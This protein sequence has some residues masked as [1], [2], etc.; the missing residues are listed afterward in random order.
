LRTVFLYVVVC[1]VAFCFDLLCLLINNHKLQQMDIRDR[2]VWVVDLC[3]YALGEGEP[4]FA[5]ES[6]GGA[7]GLFG[8]GGPLGV[9]AGSPGGGCLSLGDLEK[10]NRGDAKTQ[11]GVEEFHISI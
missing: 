1:I 10:Q 2:D 9:F 7:D 11:S 3:H 8:G 4:D 6:G 5:F